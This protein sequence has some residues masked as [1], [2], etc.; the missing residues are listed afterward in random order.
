MFKVTIKTPERRKWTYFT[1][2]SSDFVVNF[3]HVIA[4]WDLFIK[5][6]V[7]MSGMSEL[8]N[9]N[10]DPSRVALRNDIHFRTVSFQIMGDLTI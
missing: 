5:G 3:Q 2:C 1:P 9:V 6:I 7:D 10:K 8:S 4:G